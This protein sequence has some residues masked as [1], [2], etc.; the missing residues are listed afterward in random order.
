M[1]AELMTT[2]KDWICKYIEHDSLLEN[3][4]DE[5]LSEEERQSAWKE[6]EDEKKGIK[7]A[8]PGNITT[9]AHFLIEKL[10]NLL[11]HS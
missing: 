9:L 3:Q 5:V 6:Y 2:H 10:S 11:L 8:T 4:Q 1:L 7:P